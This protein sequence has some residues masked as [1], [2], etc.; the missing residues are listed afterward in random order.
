MISFSA[1]VLATALAVGVGAADD[2]PVILKVEKNDV[3]AIQKALKGGPNNSPFQQLD[4]TNPGK[5]EAGRLCHKGGWIDIEVLQVLDSTNMLCIYAIRFASQGL[6]NK[7]VFCWLK[8]DS[9]EGRTDGEKIDA[10]NMLFIHRGT[11]Q[12]TTA[13]GGTKTVNVYELVSPETIAA[14]QEGRTVVQVA[15]KTRE[16]T[17][18]SG[19]FSVKA[20]IIGYKD[21]SAQLLTD[22]EKLI[23]VPLSKLSD[24]D[25]AHVRDYI[26]QLRESTKGQPK[27]R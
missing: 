27:R 23:S 24:K 7:D 1:G 5:G 4:V 18:I 22:S 20:A 11:K 21:G 14:I 13:E 3:E 16:W 19:K 6:A 15:E 17:D 9:T 25:Q 8:V 10:D 12:Y 26:K 2:K